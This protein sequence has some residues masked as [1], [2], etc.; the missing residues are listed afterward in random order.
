M[1]VTGKNDLLGA[2]RRDKLER[3]LIYLRGSVSWVEK[4]E[5]VPLEAFYVLH[6]QGKVRHRLEAQFGLQGVQNVLGREGG[7]QFG[8][9]KIKKKIPQVTKCLPLKFC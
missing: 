2:A 3:Y 8:F 6:H 4:S 9:S 1:K 7:G 5:L